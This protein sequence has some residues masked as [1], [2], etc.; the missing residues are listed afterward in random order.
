M[1]ETRVEKVV[2]NLREMGLSQMLVCDPTSIWYLTGYMT[3]PYE[4]FLALLVSAE[5]EPVLFVNQ[6]FPDASQACPNVVVTSDTDDPLAAVIE[7]VD[8]AKAL[9]VDKDLAARWLLPLVEAGAATSFRLSSEAI[10]GA[11]RI[12]DAR[13]QRLMR[14]ASATNDKAMAWLVAQ[15]HEGVTEHEIAEGLL[16][17]Y[18]SLGAQDHSFSPIVSF[19]ANAADPHHEPDD[20]TLSYGEVVLFDVGCRQDGYCSDM[21]RTLF[22]GVPSDQDRNVFE[23]VREANL[24]GEAAVAPGVPLREIDK[25]ARDVIERAGYG[26][27]FTHRLGHQIG[28]L[29]HEPGDVSSTDELLAAPGMCFSIEPGIYLPDR[30]GVRIE[31]LVIVT[32]DGCEVLNAYPK[33]MQVL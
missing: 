21:T 26:E 29:D 27:Y 25:A 17:E 4:R 30:M 16:G 33:D 28:L 19:G 1:N 11:R 9:G 18:R 7:S 13:E 24:A 6:L 3:E 8:H 32:E 5:H 31:D 10:D 23:V 14:V 12:K 15:L 22:F 20:T 2:G